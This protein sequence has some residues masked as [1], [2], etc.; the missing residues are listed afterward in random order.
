[1][2][3]VL[4]TAI[5]VVSSFLFASETSTPKIVPSVGS[6]LTWKYERTSISIYRNS[7]WDAKYSYN[8]FRLS[9]DSGEVT[10]NIVSESPDSVQW[11]RFEIRQTVLLSRTDTTDT[12]ST[13]V[14]TVYH[15]P[16]WSRILVR[17]TV[18]VAL[19]V[20]HNTGLAF[21]SPNSLFPLQ[22]GWWSGGP[23]ITASEGRSLL[24]RDGID[25]LFY[26]HSIDTSWNA[27]I[28]N[29]VS[30]TTVILRLIPERSQIQQG[31]G[32]RPHAPTAPPTLQELS[33]RHPEIIVKWT[34]ASGRSGTIP[35][36]ALAFLPSDLHNRSLI[37][38]ARLPDGR[39]WQST[40]IL[41]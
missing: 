5:L 28:E 33:E 10:W 1:M 16:R 18:T 6:V 26:E 29:R 31:T 7:G 34:L 38:Q 13:F 12:S 22:Q 20:D 8:S 35:A 14:G 37:L 3:R 4:F 41:R 27:N 23:T 39:P 36:S 9:Q 17:G 25:S 15:T 32:V 2:L 24:F 11:R 21:A 19:R 40:T 30:D